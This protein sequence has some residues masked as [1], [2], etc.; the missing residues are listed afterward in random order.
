MHRPALQ[1]FANGP[2]AASQILLLKR[3]QLSSQTLLLE[4]KRLTVMNELRPQHWTLAGASPAW[5]PATS[6]AAGHAEQC[7][8]W[9][10]AAGDKCQGPAG[11]AAAAQLKAGTRAR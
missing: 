2:L 6:W 11:T 7:D 8:L 5:R 4:Q 10:W 9:C 1:E 3:Q